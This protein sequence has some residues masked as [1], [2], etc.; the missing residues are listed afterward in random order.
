MPRESYH[1][2]SDNKDD[3]KAVVLT[4]VCRDCSMVYNEVVCSGKINTDI[5]KAALPNRIDESSIVITDGLSAYRK[6][7]HKSKM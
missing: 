7:F 1:R 5:L 3:V 2:G 4:G 6:Y